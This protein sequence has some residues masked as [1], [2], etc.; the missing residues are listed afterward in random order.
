MKKEIIL[1]ALV[2]AVAILGLIQ[3][4]HSEAYACVTCDAEACVCD[5]YGGSGVPTKVCCPNGAP[6]NITC[7][8]FC[9]DIH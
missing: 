8:A 1:F 2:V 3:L 6:P 7:A 4:F 5:G 9:A